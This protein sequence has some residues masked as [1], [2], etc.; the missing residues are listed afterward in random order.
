M[1]LNMFHGCVPTQCFHSVSNLKILNYFYFIKTFWKALCL[2]AMILM[3]THYMHGN[4]DSSCRRPPKFSLLC[5]K[6]LW[7]KSHHDNEYIQ[8]EMTNNMNNL[9]IQYLSMI[10][11]FIIYYQGKWSINEPYIFKERF[12]RFYCS[13][14]KTDSLQT[15]LK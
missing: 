3:R 6:R 15:P 12:K 14:P 7:L 1:S 11:C 4:L 8:T 5:Y 10:F 9:K 13:L 2:L